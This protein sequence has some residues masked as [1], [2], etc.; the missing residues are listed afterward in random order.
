MSDG[1]TF[2][3]TEERWL[4]CLDLQ[5]KPMKEELSLREVFVQAHQLSAI[6]DDSPLVTIALYR[7]L[8]AV[9]YHAIYLDLKRTTKVDDWRQLWEQR[10]AGFDTRL[11]DNYFQ[12]FNNPNRFDLFHPQ[13]PFYQNLDAM[14]DD[15]FPKS[16]AELVP[17]ISWG[18]NATLLDHR[19]ER[20]GFSLTP[21][22]SARRRLYASKKRKKLSLVTPT[23][24]STFG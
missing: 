1:I 5:G 20:D 10:H 2:D 7:F 19:F 23:F 12:R 16:V 21:A 9:L 4:P 6:Q 15:S 8:L 18:N 14:G 22:E 13:Y 3:L 17:E 11:L 24:P